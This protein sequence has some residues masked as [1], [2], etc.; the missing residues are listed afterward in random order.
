MMDNMTKTWKYKDLAI[1]IE[2]CSTLYKQYVGEELEINEDDLL[3]VCNLLFNKFCQSTVAFDTI[4]DFYRKFFI[5]FYDE[6]DY[7]CQKM[8]QIKHL[9]SLN[10]NDLLTEYENI[11]NMAN[12]DNKIVDNPLYSVIP[13][14]TTQSTSTS[15]INKVMAISRAIATYR[16][17]EVNYFLD[18]F[19]TLFY[20]VFG[21][22]KYFYV[23][24][25]NYGYFLQ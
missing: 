22:Q 24:G 8:K 16:N 4:S 25:E 9:R 13:F 20:T 3:L 21:V 17:N 19:K 6:V 10:G 1:T 2:N 7:F 18:K 14:I 23:G 11:S 12:N 5:V 15:K